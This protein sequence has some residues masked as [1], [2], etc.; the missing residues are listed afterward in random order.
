MFG[1]ENCW[2]DLN[3]STSRCD[4]IRGNAIK[5]YFPHSHIPH[6]HMDNLCLQ[7]Y[8][9]LYLCLWKGINF[10]S[11]ECFICLLVYFM[12][13]LSTFCCC[14]RSVLADLSP[15]RNPISFPKFSAPCRTTLILAYFNLQASPGLFPVTFQALGSGWSKSFKWW[16]NGILTRYDSISFCR[17]DLF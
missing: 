2:L 6:F 11:L 13:W 3:W 15:L 10:C 16:H 14:F 4:E 1:F 17:P 12:L 7:R 5:L 9:C 8:A